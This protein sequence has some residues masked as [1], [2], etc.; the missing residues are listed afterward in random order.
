MRKGKCLPFTAKV[1][2]TPKLNAWNASITIMAAITCFL[3]NKARSM[4]VLGLKSVDQRP[5]GR[6]DL[7]SLLPE[8]FFQQFIQ[9]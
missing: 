2:T 1:M 3:R 6:K 7:G 4:S 9:R 5:Q 8:L